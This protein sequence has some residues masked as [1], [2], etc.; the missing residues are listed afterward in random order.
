MRTQIEEAR[1]TRWLHLL[2]DCNY[3]SMCL[4]RM[5]IYI[6]LLSHYHITNAC[7]WNHY[8]SLFSDVREWDTTNHQ[9][10]CK[11]VEHNAMPS[12]AIEA[13]TSCDDIK[14]KDIMKL[15]PTRCTA[16]WWFFSTFVFLKYILGSAGDELLKLLLIFFFKW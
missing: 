2:Y 9:G 14:H 16:L 12:L 11:Q 7:W 13:N 1:R 3:G 6:S 15:Y 5:Y 8:E 4:S 10:C